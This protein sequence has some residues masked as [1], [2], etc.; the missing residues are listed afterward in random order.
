[1]HRWNLAQASDLYVSVNLS[2]KQL[3]DP[4]LIATVGKALE[5]SGL[6]AGHL[7]VEVTE[8][9]L[10]DEFDFV[11]SVFTSLRSM[12]VQIYLH[13]F[14]TGYSSLEYLLRLPF[15]IVKIDQSFVSALN[16]DPNALLTS[17]RLLVLPE[18]ISNHAV[19][20]EVMTGRFTVSASPSASRTMCTGMERSPLDRVP[21]QAGQGYGQNDLQKTR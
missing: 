8:S 18:S 14:G 15:G 7:E 6:P 11:C 1:M 19:P 16:K 12:G 5:N 2:A 3:L 21:G 17:I 4:G 10:L 9:V 13:E 20:A